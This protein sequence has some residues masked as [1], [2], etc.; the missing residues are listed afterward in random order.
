VLFGFP[1][2]QTALG[3]ENTPSGGKAMGAGQPVPYHLF[4]EIRNGASP[5]RGVTSHNDRGEA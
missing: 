4:R 1:L 2:D 5:A 3:N